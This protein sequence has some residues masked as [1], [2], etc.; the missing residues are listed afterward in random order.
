MKEH[1]LQ[2]FQDVTKTGTTLITL[3]FEC[4]KAY[5]AYGICREKMG[6]IMVN[7]FVRSVRPH[8]DI[9]NQSGGRTTLFLLSFLSPVQYFFSPRF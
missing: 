5:V 2:V 6:K 4:M 1:V 7:F 3:L 9:R 8:L